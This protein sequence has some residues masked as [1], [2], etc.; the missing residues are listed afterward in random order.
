MRRI[1]VAMQM[2]GMNFGTRSSVATATPAFGKQYSQ[3]N[4]LRKHSDRGLAAENQSHVCHAG[5]PQTG[6]GQLRRR[7][8]VSGLPGA[9][10]FPERQA[11]DTIP[12]GIQNVEP[13]PQK[14]PASADQW[15]A[16]EKLWDIDEKFVD[17]HT[18]TTSV[19][20]IRGKIESDG[21]APCIKTVYGMGYQWTGGEA[22]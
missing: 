15:A 9:G 21:G 10:G 19:S 14:S 16:S 5:T 17:E 11:P 18:L 6:Q 4:I 8:A 1:R 7:A 2:A 20:R 13:V 3:K 12:D 22:K